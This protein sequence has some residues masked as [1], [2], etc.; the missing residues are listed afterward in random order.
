[1]FVSS[2]DRKR[3][4]VVCVFLSALFSLLIGKFYQIQIVEQ[5]KWERLANLQHKRFLVEPFRRGSFYSNT[6]IKKGHPENP[7]KLVYDAPRIHVF[8]N[9]N[10]FSL[11][12]KQVITCALSRRLLLEEKQID[13]MKK[14][15]HVKSKLRRIL[16]WLE[17]TLQ[18][19]IE[20]WWKGFAKQNHLPKN[21]LHFLKEY[22]RYYPFGSMLGPLLHTVQE[23]R[24]PLT[25]RAVPTGGLEL[26]FHLYL[27]GKP[28]K[29]WI[30][31]SSRNALGKSV[32]VEPPEHGADVYLTI[33]HYIQTIAEKKLEEGVKKAQ[34]KGGWL[35]IMDP[36]SGDILSIAQYPFFDPSSYA[37][38]F[39]DPVKQEATKLKA[40][41]DAFEPASI[42]K[43]ITMTLALQANQD[44]LAQG[45]AALFDP[46]EKIP[47]KNI[48][49]PKTRFRLKDGV[50]RRF[51]NM[52][53]AIQKSA[54]VYTGLI[55]QRMLETYGAHWIREQYVER[56][57]L[58]KKTGIEVPAEHPG[59]VPTPG[60][61]HPN[62]K[63]EWS[64]ATPYSLAIGHNILVNS[65]QMIQVYAAIAN[66][67]YLVQPTIIKEIVKEGKVVF[68]PK[69]KA[70]KK[71]LDAYAVRETKAGLKYATKK[72][73]T[74]PRG[75][76]RGY[77]EAGKSGTSEK[78]IQGKYSQS[79]YFSV[80]CGFAPA[81]NPAFVMLVVLDEPKK[82]FIPG[83]G[84]N[85]MGGTSA[86]PI[87]S[88]V[89]EEA[90]H[91]LG[92]DPDDPNNQ[93]WKQETEELIRL[94]K[95]WNGL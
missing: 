9:P 44:A 5:E 93:D 76:I 2:S 12:Q 85:H 64:H 35:V 81:E 66:G 27:T 65:I 14:Q 41:T 18:E 92:V 71:I 16:S 47:T 70:P 3:L 36:Y 19:K 50:E 13:A 28:G 45:K 29:K 73:G 51:M 72:R 34:A 74:S 95:E 69:K 21:A 52:Y 80:F 82:V 90:L 94:Y 1:M 4:L 30:Y 32:L 68:T 55:M 60:K 8:V 61:L 57:R 83:V 89:A 78:I 67:G 86:A 38:Y 39:S 58:G 6:S 62:G 43:V 75:A 56:F 63:L 10:A 88:A 15:L 84:K 24:N 37:K 40:V 20:T 48:R 91:Y 77:S 17:P 33:N 22:K 7:Q 23:R 79:K 54:N 26:Q 46:H 42:F 25:H 49:F 31:R 59:M 11:Q 87:F 53:L